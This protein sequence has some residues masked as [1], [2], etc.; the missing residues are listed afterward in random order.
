VDKGSR[1]NRCEDTGMANDDG[2][3]GDMAPAMRGK[4]DTKCLVLVTFANCTGMNI[5]VAGARDLQEND[6]VLT[7]LGRRP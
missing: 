6:S 5:D 3:D 7:A 1:E 2:V 4:S